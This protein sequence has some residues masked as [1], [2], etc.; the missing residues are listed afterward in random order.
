MR[1][2]AAVVGNAATSAVVLGITWIVASDAIIDLIQEVLNRNT[3]PLPQIR[4]GPAAV[5]PVKRVIV[6]FWRVF[7]WSKRQNSHKSLNVLR[8]PFRVRT[9][10]RPNARDPKLDEAARGDVV[11]N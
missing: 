11:K 7:F 4:W 5:F 9:P 8:C 2:D 10:V 1:N 3:E 6:E